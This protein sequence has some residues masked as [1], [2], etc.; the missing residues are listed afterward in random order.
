MHYLEMKKLQ[1]ENK[2]FVSII[3]NDPVPV[4]LVITQFAE[5]LGW[6]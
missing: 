1:S 4:E 2:T 6:D 5:K 3:A